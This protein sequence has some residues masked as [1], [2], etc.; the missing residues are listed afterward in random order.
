MYF[1]L[2]K[3]VLHY[4][5]IINKKKFHTAPKDN[6]AKKISAYA[7]ICLHKLKNFAKIIVKADYRGVFYE[8]YREN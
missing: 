2:F 3:Y 7:N 6:S 8:P 4:L 5:D 1:L